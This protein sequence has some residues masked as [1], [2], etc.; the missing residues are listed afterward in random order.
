MGGV[1]HNSLTEFFSDRTG[2]RFGGICRSKY[3]PNFPN[4]IFALINQGDTCFAPRGVTL[5]W[6]TFARRHPSHEFDDALPSFSAFG[7]TEFFFEDAQNRS[8]ELLRL[9]NAH[10]MDLKSNNVE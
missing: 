5:L 9:G 10:T 4:G 6:W 7:R 2:R 8:I 3:V 1:D